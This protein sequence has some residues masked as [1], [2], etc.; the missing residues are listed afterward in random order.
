MLVQ[1]WAVW[2]GLNIGLNFMIINKAISVLVCNFVSHDRCMQVVVTPC[3]SIATSLVK[4]SL[5]LFYIL[6]YQVRH[7][8]LTAPFSD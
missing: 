4:V 7:F 3:I 6:C 2:T 5:S 1:G 8:T